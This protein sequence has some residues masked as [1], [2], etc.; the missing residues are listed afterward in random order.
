MHDAA[1]DSLAELVASG[2]ITAAERARMVVPGRI[3][4]RAQL[5]APFGETGVFAGLTVEQCD[6][7]PMPEAA[8][9]AYCESGDAQ[10]LAAD[11]TGFFRSVFVPSLAAALEPTRPPSDSV[12]FADALAAI[13]ERKMAAELRELPATGAILV[14]ARQTS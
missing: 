12:A 13:M 2:T 11:R 6:I 9:S 7:F 1:N 5:L 4:G 3:R 14:L 10:A 8:W